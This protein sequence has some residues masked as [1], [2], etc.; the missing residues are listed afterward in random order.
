MVHGVLSPT[1]LS[2]SLDKGQETS[3]QVFY[4]TIREESD[5]VLIMSLGSITVDYPV[6]LAWGASVCFSMK[7]CPRGELRGASEK[8]SKKEV[9]RKHSGLFPKT[10]ILDTSA[11]DSCIARLCNEPTNNKHRTR[12]NN[13]GCAMLIAHKSQWGGMEHRRYT[14]IIF[15]SEVPLLGRSTR[16][17]TSGGEFGWGGTSV[18]R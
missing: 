6:N 2:H 8:K 4:G 7:R 10:N 12:S 3:Y 1:P 18:K 17:T 15:W 9:G 14:I 16:E 11:T 5:G 13:H